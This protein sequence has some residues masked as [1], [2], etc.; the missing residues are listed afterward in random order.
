MPGS[1]KSTIGAMLAKELDMPLVDIDEE[2]EK[3]AGVSIPEIFAKEGETGFRSREAEQIARFGSIGGSVLVTGGGAIKSEA[4]RRTLQMNGFVAHITR[5]LS[6]LP[7]D[8]RPLSQ[9]RERLSE[10]WQERKALY[11]DCADLRVSNDAAPEACVQ[12][13]KEAFHEALCHQRT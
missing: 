12:K 3:A 11:A 1:G 8:G 2:I 10:M 13:I 4:N 6:Q 9:S 7:M 5:D